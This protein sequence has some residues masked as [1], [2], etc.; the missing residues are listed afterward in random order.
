MTNGPE[1]QEAPAEIDDIAVDERHRERGRAGRADFA[2][3][4]KQAIERD[5][6]FAAARRMRPEKP[7]CDCLVTFR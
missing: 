1:Q 3:I 6:E 2:S 4:A 7:R 5:D